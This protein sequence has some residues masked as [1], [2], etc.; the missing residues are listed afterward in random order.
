LSAHNQVEMSDEES[1]D[2]LYGGYGLQY[3]S[4][5]LLESDKLDLESEYS[6]SR[7]YIC[8]MNVDELKEEDQEDEMSE[9]SNDKEDKVKLLT[10]LLEA[11]K[12]QLELVVEENIELEERVNQL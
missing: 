2:K 5:E 1:K 7:T 8:S 4:S 3:T 12:E 11:K 9:D 6:D 10:K